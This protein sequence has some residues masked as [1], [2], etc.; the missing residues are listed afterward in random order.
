MRVYKCIPNYFKQIKSGKKIA[1]LG[2]STKGNVALSFFDIGVE[3]V[4]FIGDVNSD[5]FAVSFV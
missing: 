3:E 2:A 4:S 1:G 5:K